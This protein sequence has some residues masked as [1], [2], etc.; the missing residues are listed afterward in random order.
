M[1]ERSYYQAVRGTLLHTAWRRVRE[2]G[3]ESLSQETRDAIKAFDVKAL[4][5]LRR[6]ERQL[7]ER[8]FR[9]K[10][11]MG[12]PKRRPGKKP[13]PLVIAAI[14][15]RIVQRA[16]L[17]VLQLSPPIR[18]IYENPASFGGIKERGRQHAI[19]AVF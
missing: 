15:N 4:Q 19:A 10:P 13:R 2:N 17:D 18:Q 9:F 16:I 5:H 11:Q 7:R 12:I 6:I 1:G 8:R 14:E 3:L